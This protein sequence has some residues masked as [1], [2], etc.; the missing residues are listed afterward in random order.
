MFDPIKRIC[1]E[2]EK[3]KIDGHC[4]SYRECRIVNSVSHVEKWNLMKCPS[5][6]HFDE[7]SKNCIESVESICGKN[8]SI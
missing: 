6:Y 1:R 5:N 2:K 7:I 3:M 8:F 4:S